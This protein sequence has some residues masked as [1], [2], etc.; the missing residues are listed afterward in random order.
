M[1]TMTIRL[2]PLKET[3]RTGF[4]SNDEGAV[5][6]PS[7]RPGG[8]DNVD[9]GLERGGYSEG[10]GVKQGKHFLHESEGAALSLFGLGT[11]LDRPPPVLARLASATISRGALKE[12]PLSPSPAG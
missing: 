3:D 6:A 2:E 5:T 11:D 4:S 7:A 9:G 8:L 10:N 12:R 1:E